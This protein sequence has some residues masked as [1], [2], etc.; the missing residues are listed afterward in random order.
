ML[1][2]VLRD[3]L[4]NC[5]KELYSAEQQQ[6]RVLANLRR[7]ATDDTLRRVLRLHGEETRQ[8]AGRLER[9]FTL[10]DEPIRWARCPGVLGI[11]EECQEATDEHPAGP[12]RDAAIVAAAQRLD[13]Y[14]MAAYGA[15]AGWADALGLP[16]VA[17]LLNACLDEEVAAADELLAVAVGGV[18][19][20]AADAGRP[21]PDAAVSAAGPG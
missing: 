16:R 18:Q 8:H 14:E 6:L 5:I 9:I 13:Y 21:R 15:L 11:L 20:A 2:P 7:A 1:E 4:V 10:L 17:A 3:S 12:L 19:S